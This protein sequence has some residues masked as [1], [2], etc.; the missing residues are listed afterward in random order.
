MEASVGITAG[1]AAEIHSYMVETREI[2]EEVLV[3]ARQAVEAHDGY[4]IVLQAN[5]RQAILLPANDD[6]E[7]DESEY[8]PE[9]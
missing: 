6:E 8:D 9:R 4:S 3:S 2:A 7:E 1:E 5:G